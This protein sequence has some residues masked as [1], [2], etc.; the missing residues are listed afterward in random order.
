MAAE[1]AQLKMADVRVGMRLR[2][3]SEYLFR[4]EGVLTVTEITSAGFKFDAERDVSLGPRHG[5]ALAKGREHFGIDGI[6]RYIP[7]VEAAAPVAPRLCPYCHEPE[8][9]TNDCHVSYTAAPVPQ[10]PEQ[11]RLAG[12]LHDVARNI[13]DL[14]AV[15]RFDESVINDLH[16]AADLIQFAAQTPA[17]TRQPWTPLDGSLTIRFLQYINAK[18]AWRWHQNGGIKSWSALEWAGAMAGEAGEACNA[19]KKLKRIEDQI[20]NMR[21][22]FERLSAVL[23]ASR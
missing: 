11:K 22:A 4:Q 23:E 16:R 8:H 10:T 13:G 1:K 18:R 2:D 17:L 7:V 14:V 20:A 15:R 21:G 19:A 5:I 6:C 12:V 9:I 3:P